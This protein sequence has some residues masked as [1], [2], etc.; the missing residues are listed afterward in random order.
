LGVLDYSVWDT[1]VKAGK[2]D[3]NQ[4]SVIWESPPYPDYQWTIRG[5][6][7]ATYG[8][9]FS[10]KV[11]TALLDLNDPI[12]LGYFARSKFIPAAN[13]QY[14]PIEDVAKATNLFN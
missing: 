9:G 2:V 4:V 12:I 8:A 3:P 1:E 6:A 10:D 14:A 7:D 13:D 5:D 11:R